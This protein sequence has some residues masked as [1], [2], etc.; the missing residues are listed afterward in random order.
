[1]FLLRG[2][3][4]RLLLANSTSVCFLELCG[5]KV[6]AREVFDVSVALLYETMS[7]MSCELE[8]LMYD[9]KVCT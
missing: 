5:T 1:M 7:S 6:L 2:G 4:S 9:T 3:I 8:C